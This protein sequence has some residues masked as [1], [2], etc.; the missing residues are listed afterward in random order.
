[1]KCR[2][3]RLNSVHQNLRTDEVVGS[4]DHEPV[5]GQRFIMTAAPLNPDASVRWI[6]TTEVAERTDLVKGQT[7][8][9]K[10]LNSDYKWEFLG[11]GN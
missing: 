3:T 5:V 4:C 8:E 6:E 11:F 2:L 9:F 1:M 7:I 10:T